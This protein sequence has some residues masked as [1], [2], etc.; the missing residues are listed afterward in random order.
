[1]TPELGKILVLIGLALVMIGGLAV[2]GIRIP[3]DIVIQG[4][5]GV[6]V[7]PLGTMIVVSVVLSVIGT[8]LLRS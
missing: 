8:L 1:V 3:G 5:R 4:D 2:L 6:I 7:I